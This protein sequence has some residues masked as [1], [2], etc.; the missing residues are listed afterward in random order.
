MALFSERNGY[1]AARTIAQIEE[2]DDNLRIGIFNTIYSYYGVFYRNS[3]QIKLF[4]NIWSN[5]WHK[6]LDW[7]PSN[8]ADF[9]SELKHWIFY[10]AWYEIYD[11]LECLAI[12]EHEFVSELEEASSTASL[13]TPETIC[14]QPNP[15]NVAVNATLER[16]RSGYRIVGTQAVKITNETEI[17]E[18]ER[19]LASPDPFSGARLQ[20]EKAIEQISKRPE[21]DCSN[22]VKEAINAVEAAARIFSG[23]PKAELGKALSQIGKEGSMHPALIAGWRNLYGF[24]S[25]EGGIRHASNGDKIE[26]DYSLARYM[27]VTC[28][29][30]VNYLVDQYSGK[31][32]S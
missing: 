11:L 22:A 6:P 8:S 16:E 19:A 3:F 25:D 18:I 2:A 31:K 12:Q 28:S 13:S 7:F 4:K 29:A 14:P 9:Y 23:S 17:S 24:T 15:F 27:V 5:L 20:I 30:F 32:Q 21:A 10:C 1:S 26:V